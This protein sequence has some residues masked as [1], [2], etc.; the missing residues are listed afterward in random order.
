[1]RKL[2][3]ILA[4]L[5]TFSLASC[6]GTKTVTPHPNALDLAADV[7]NLTQLDFTFSSRDTDTSYNEGS[8]VKITLENSTAQIS[9]DGAVITDGDIVISKEGTYVLS[10][11]YT[12]GML[13]IEC[14]DTEK[15]QIVLNGAEIVSPDSPAIYVKQADKVF[16]T[17]VKDTENKLVDGDKYSIIDGNSE[18]DATLFSRSDTTINGEGKLT[19]IGTNKH[20]IISKDDLV[21]AG[22]DISVRSKKV[23][24]TGK[25]CVKIDKATITINAGS[26]G[27]RSDNND[28]ANRGFVYI[29][30]G[31]IDIT[32][33]KDGIQAENVLYVKDGSIKL[34]CGGGCANTVESLKP[35]D[36][37]PTVLDPNKTS[38][39]EK[40]ESYKGLK[41][42]SDIVI[43]GGT[44][45][46]D[47]ADVCM[48][49]NGSITVGGGAI[50]LSSGGDAIN[51]DK[52]YIQNGGALYTVKCINA[53]AAAN[54]LING[55]EASIIA[56]ELGISATSRIEVRYGY[57]ITDTT[58]SAVNSSEFFLVSGGTV[59][60]NPPVDESKPVIASPSIITAGGNFVALGNVAVNATDTA[61][62][63][64][65]QSGFDKQNADTSIFL[66]DAKDNFLISFNS[67]RAYSTA[68]IS[69]PYIKEGTYVIYS[70][71]KLEN[72]DAN[73]FSYGGRLAGATQIASVE[74][75]K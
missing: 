70:G 11:K 44:I 18:I 58:L 62:Q 42:D 64:S 33:E 66:C 16:F 23:G 71:A 63:Y 15:V 22:G 40:P 56:S 30:S 75:Q 5:L 29:L 57:V 10:G 59:L 51:T 6:T 13:K 49:A 37:Q 9:G 3:L 65:V 55:G 41:S 17:L 69:S 2:S 25:D 14:T 46:A 61:Y 19:V 38:D 12:A 43:L 50:K 54:V 39:E 34:N 36:K 20:G 31:K 8:A 47:T 1:M 52:A 53:I 74:I 28:D 26:D 21:I 48:Q 67:K 4:L 68:L 45:I 72:S 32:A 7:A 73:G 35:S 60:L 27:I 24:I